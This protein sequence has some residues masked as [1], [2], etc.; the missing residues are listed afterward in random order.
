MEKEEIFRIFDA[1]KPTVAVVREYLE[2]ISG[3]APFDVIF[4]QN[5]IERITNQL[6]PNLGEPVGVVMDRTIFYFRSLCKDDFDANIENLTVEDV[7]SFAK[8]LHSKAF[9]FNNLS[10]DVLCRN[11]VLLS[12]TLEMLRVF[13]YKT[14]FFGDSYLL[15]NHYNPS[16][17]EGE[18]F[19][20][21]HGDD[22]KTNI[23]HFL[24]SYGNIYFYAG[25]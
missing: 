8:K 25:L 7:L 20:F 23:L 10:M 11:R 12:E 15:F 9:P 16:S 4:L 21:Q 19:D 1:C 3:L 13:G 5:G 24:R 18:Y 2:R 6:A 17:Q 14:P 22:G